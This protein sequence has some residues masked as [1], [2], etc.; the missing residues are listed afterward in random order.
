MTR[1]RLL[2]LFCGAG[3][4]AMGYHRAGFDVV[5]VDIAPQPHYPFEFHQADAMTVLSDLADKGCAITALG[6][7]LHLADFDAIHASPPCQTY[8]SI[9]HT[10][11]GQANRDNH[12]DLVDP[13]RSELQRIGLPWVMEN[14]EG[15]PMSDVLMLCG[16][17]FDLGLHPARKVYLK[18]HRLFEASLFLWPPA[19][20][21]HTGRALAVYGHTGG[22][23]RR[24][25]GGAAFG[26]KS[27][28]MDAMQIDWMN[29]DMIAEAIPPAYTEWI[30]AQLLR[31]LGVA[32]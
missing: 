6:S 11:G 9:T 2:D 32:A 13:V 8:S 1:P 21:A 3:G 22:Q 5:G 14:V 4:A 24:D 16:S 29:A 17:M 25:G 31:A 28:W 30:G 20:C 12:P 18:R 19:P 10:N 7:E 27:E 15:A 23:S 26:S